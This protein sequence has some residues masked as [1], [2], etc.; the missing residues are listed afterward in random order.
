MTNHNTQESQP[1]LEDSPVPA[2]EDVPEIAHETNAELAPHPVPEAVS[3]PLSIEPALK[4]AAP[5][6]SAPSQASILESNLEPKVEQSAEPIVEEPAESFAEML[7]Q[8]EKS[9]SHKG[10]PGQKQLQGT[11]V[12]L[13]ADQVFLDIGYKT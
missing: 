7:S 10:A 2:S 1:V 6:K 9:H 11:V 4:P 5:P 12:S 8:F 3:A 13:S